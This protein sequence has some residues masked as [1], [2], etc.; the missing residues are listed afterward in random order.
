ME[1]FL[2]DISRYWDGVGK[3]MIDD[4]GG[5]IIDN[6]RK[7]RQIVLRILNRHNL[8]EKNV[9]EIGTGNGV[10]GASLFLSFATLRYHGLD[11]SPFFC[12]SASK[13]F[14]LKVKLGS[15]TAIPYEDKF[16]DVVMAFDT[17]EHIPPED[18]EKAYSEMGRVLKRPGI[19][20]INNPLCQSLHPPK[21]D[22]GFTHEDMEILAKKIHGRVTHLDAYSVPVLDQNSDDLMS[23][24]F[25]EITK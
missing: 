3:K 10:I 24:E 7:K 9:L 17:L 12:E 19:I 2:D 14:S 21:Y 22:F 16:F 6:W 5:R 23:Y 20:L 11:I 13:R 15:I 25:V 1:S 8:E 18:R 4:A